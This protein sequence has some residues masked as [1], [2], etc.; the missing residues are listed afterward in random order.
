[1]IYVFLAVLLV[2]AARTIFFIRGI[3]K[4]S[5]LVKS[6]LPN[7]KLPF[8]SVLIPARNEEDNLERCIES[9]LANDYPKDK[10]EILCINDC[11][12]D[13][14][15]KILK[16]YTAKHKNIRYRT[17]TVSDRPLK[18]AGKPGALQSGF[19]IAKGEYVLM[20]DADC[21]VDKKWIRSVVDTFVEE[22]ADLV[23]GLSHL[24]YKG[25]FGRIQSIEWFYM[26]R[27]AA[28]GIGNNIPLGCFGNNLSL[29]KKII[30]ESGGFRKLP[31]S[32][33]EDLLLMQTVHGLGGK[34]RYLT[35]PEGSIL[36]LP[37]PDIKRYIKQHHRW[38][39]GGKKLGRFAFLFVLTSAAIWLGLGTSLFLGAWGFFF[40]ILGVRLLG[41]ILI[42]GNTFK[43]HNRPHLLLAYLPAGF[44]ALLL[45]ELLS[46]FFLLK[47]TVEWKGRKFKM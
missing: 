11:S 22:K 37:A 3:R 21:V 25:F 12:N 34:I 7:E 29:S 27:L 4:Q 10:Y 41:D 47:T 44:L 42:L 5:Y 30:T 20:T 17:L 46:P 28:G 43:E 2:W 16:N 19:D 36:S 39:H 33:T 35:A 13:K 38:T 26:S 15:E 32:V 18:L 45:S 6:N 14:T 1:M 9:V 40:G 24:D 31:F 8:I 23:L